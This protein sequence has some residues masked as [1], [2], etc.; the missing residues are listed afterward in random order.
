MKGQATLGSRPNRQLHR[1]P[2]LQLD[3]ASMDIRALFRETSACRATILPTGR[4]AMVRSRR[5][6][7][8]GVHRQ[9]TIPIST[10][11]RPGRSQNR[12]CCRVQGI[13]RRHNRAPL[14]NTTH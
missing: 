8:P 5:K 4:Y 10:A 6:I 13:S 3:Q 14:S 1:W 11:F 7:G 9:Q 12:S 2:Q